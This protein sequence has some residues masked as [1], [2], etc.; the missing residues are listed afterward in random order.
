MLDISVDEAGADPIRTIGRLLERF[1]CPVSLRGGE[2]F[3]AAPGGP[4]YREESGTPGLGTSG[5]GD[6]LTG[7]LTGLLARGTD[8]LAAM[9]WAVHVHAQSGLRLSGRIGELG[10]LARELLDEMASVATEL[11][12]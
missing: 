1:G 9:V 4:I 2:T 6:V 5:S 11:S 10:Y 12:A 8:P 3:T 7:F